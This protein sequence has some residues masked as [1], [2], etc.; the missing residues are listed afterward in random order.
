MIVVDILRWAL[1]LLMVGVVVGWL[2]GVRRGSESLRDEAGRLKPVP[3]VI[4]I[5]AGL[6]VI[7][8]IVGLVHLDDVQGSCAQAACR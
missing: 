7:G 5:V 1:F 6:I 4:V 2:D 3:A 8:L